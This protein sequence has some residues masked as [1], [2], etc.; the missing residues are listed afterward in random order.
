MNQGLLNFRFMPSSPLDHELSNYRNVLILIQHASTCQERAINLHTANT[1]TVSES[2]N[3]PHV[4][5]ALTHSYYSPLF[6]SGSC[7]VKHILR[8]PVQTVH[9][10]YT[11][12]MTSMDFSPLNVD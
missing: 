10:S 4:L 2:A 3:S 6:V 12:L 11:S 7:C 8:P 1:G 5:R 9:V